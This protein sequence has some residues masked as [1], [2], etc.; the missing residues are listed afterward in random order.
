MQ[1][2]DNVMD[3][4]KLTVSLKEMLDAL[5][6]YDDMEEYGSYLDSRTG[7]VFHV[8][9]DEMVDDESNLGLYQEIVNYP[10]RYIQLPDQRYVFEKAGREQVWQKVM[11]K[12]VSEKVENPKQK[13]K[14]HKVIKKFVRWGGGIVGFLSQLDPS[15]QTEWWNYSDAQNT[16]FARE[17]CAANNITLVE[18]EV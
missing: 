9:D 8:Y 3:A 4:T 17:W 7:K 15:Q 1:R 11:E 16:L 2:K 6:Y 5:D 12:F 18:E 13:K 14:L 10:E